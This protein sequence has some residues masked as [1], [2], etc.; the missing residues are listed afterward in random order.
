MDTGAAGTA[1][2]AGNAGIASDTIH[3][4]TSGMPSASMGV[5]SEERRQLIAE[6]AYYRSE[7]RSFMPGHELDDWLSAE[8]EIEV[9][10]AESGKNSSSQN[11]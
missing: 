7:R 1:R 6:A 5:T 3:M 10:L 9:R 11:M 2:S 4:K 8:A